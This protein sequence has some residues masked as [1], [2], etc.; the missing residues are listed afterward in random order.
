MYT[1]V[2]YNHTELPCQFPQTHNS[3]QNFHN[4]VKMVKFQL[5]SCTCRRCHARLFYHESHD[6]CCSGGKFTFSHVNAPQELLQ[7]FSD[8]PYEGKHFRKHIKSYN[9]VLSFTSLS[10]HLNE[11]LIGTGH[12]IYSFHAQGAIYHNIGGFYPNECCRPRF[13]QLYISMIQSMNYKIG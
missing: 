3:A 4:N 13:L 10:V 6:M 12:G 11:N 2:I 1:N 8:S 5:P 7:L 9:H